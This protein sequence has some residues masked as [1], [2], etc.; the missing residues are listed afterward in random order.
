MNIMYHLDVGSFSELAGIKGLELVGGGRLIP[1]TSA[2][3]VATAIKNERG[4]YG[5]LAHRNSIAGIVEE[6]AALIRK[7]RLRKVCEVVIHIMPCLG[8]YPGSS[9]HNYIYS[10]PKALAQCS[11]FLASNYPNAKRIEVS[12]TAKGIKIVKE[13]KSGLAIGRKDYFIKERLEVIAENIANQ[14]ESYTEFYVL[15]A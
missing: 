7:Y 13:R 10:H 11:D 12:S 8:A 1:L 14:G 9:N 6:N 3:E 15:S 5:T 4:S 2:R